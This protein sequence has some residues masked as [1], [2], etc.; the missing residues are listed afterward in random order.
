MKEMQLH[1]PANAN[2]NANP[3]ANAIVEINEL[4]SAIAVIK[5]WLIF[6]LKRKC[7]SADQ[8]QEMHWETSVFGWMFNFNG[9]YCPSGQKSQ[10]K[11]AAPHWPVNPRQMGSMVFISQAFP[12]GFPLSKKDV[13][14]F[15]LSNSEQPSW[16]YIL[17][18]KTT[19]EGLISS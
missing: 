14:F 5:V 12:G 7:L 15:F 18:Y 16:Y 4:E 17:P 8:R 3:N 11:T 2:G 13:A 19:K 6:G 10:P 9:K 1:F